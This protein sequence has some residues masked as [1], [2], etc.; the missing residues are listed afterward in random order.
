MA[1]HMLTYINYMG[2]IV[3][4]LALGAHNLSLDNFFLKRK[5]AQQKTTI[6]NT[7]PPSGKNLKLDE[8]SKFCDPTCLFR[9]ITHLCFCALH[10]IVYNNLGLMTIIAIPSP[11]QA[12][13]F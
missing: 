5:L 2:E 7:S 3:V 9:H 1:E 6:K 12:P 4:L 8:R 11:R 10:E 13:R